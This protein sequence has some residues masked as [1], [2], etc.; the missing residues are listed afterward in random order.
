MMQKKLRSTSP[1]NLD[2]VRLSAI[3]E[4]VPPEITYSD[5]RI[6]LAWLQKGKIDFN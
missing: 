1:E 3:K 2:E 4:S 5:L 6:V